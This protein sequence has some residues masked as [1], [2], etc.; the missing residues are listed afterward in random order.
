MSLSLCFNCDVSCF[1]FLLFSIQIEEIFTIIL[2]ICVH[3]GIIQAAK[4]LP[5]TDGIA[6]NVTIK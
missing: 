1:A 6:N 5:L 2:L 3:V 4:L